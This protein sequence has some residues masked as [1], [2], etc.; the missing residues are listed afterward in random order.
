MHQDYEGEKKG[1]GVDRIEVKAAVS[2]YL[3]T[4]F[5]LSNDGDWK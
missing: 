3:S 1:D 4:Y 2:K 5:N